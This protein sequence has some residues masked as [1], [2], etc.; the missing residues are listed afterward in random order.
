MGM[1]ASCSGGVCTFA[2]TSD[3]ARYSAASAWTNNQDFSASSKFLIRTA[4]S[5]PATCE[6][7]EK[8]FNT[9]TPAFRNC[10]TTN[11][12]ANE[13]GASSVTLTNLYPV[14]YSY[15]PG[16]NFTYSAN[17]VF[18]HISIDPIWAATVVR[19]ASTYIATADASGSPNKYLGVALYTV[20]GNRISSA[21]TTGLSFATTGTDKTLDLGDTNL[22]TGNFLLCSTANTSSGEVISNFET[23]TYMGTVLKRVFTCSETSS[24]SGSTITWPSTCTST[25]ARSPGTAFPLFMLSR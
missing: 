11:T 24:T 23:G 18:C 4:A 14:G 19:Y 10:P 1:N 6:P 3:V 12:W 22:P 2:V 25:T 16:V 20:A 15:K 9:A 8:Y 21:T 5:D 13:G 17:V 7:G